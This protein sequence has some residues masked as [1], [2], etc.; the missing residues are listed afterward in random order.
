MMVKGNAKTTNMKPPWGPNNQ[1]RSGSEGSRSGLMEY[2]MCPS[3]LRDFLN[4]KRVWGL[5]GDNYIENQA[6]EKD[7]Y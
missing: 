4:W 6:K 2:L 5:F 7:N 3:I 1:D